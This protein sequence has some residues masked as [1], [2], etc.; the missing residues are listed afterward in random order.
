MKKTQKPNKTQNQNNQIE[1]VINQKPLRKRIPWREYQQGKKEIELIVD[2]VFLPVRFPTYGLLLYD[3]SEEYRVSMSLRPEIME[4][5]M[6]ATGLT[7]GK[8]YR[9]RILV[10]KK[11]GEKTMITQGKEDAEYQWIS[12][13]GWRLSNITS[14]DIPF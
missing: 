11:E 14:D 6:Q 13:K 1:I 4:K 5:L 3:G 12:G 9:G 10:I 8:D 7:I 2:W